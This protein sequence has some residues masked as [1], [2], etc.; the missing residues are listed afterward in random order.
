MRLLKKYRTYTYTSLVLVVL[1]GFVSN[2]HL[3]RRVNFR[4]ADEVLYSYQE[5][6][7]DFG[8]KHGTLE[9]LIAVNSKFGK[10]TRVGDDFDLGDTDGVIKDT[11]AYDYYQEEQIIYRKMLFSLSTGDG[12]YL[13][14]L[15]LPTLEEDY[16]VTTILFSL[17]IFTLLFILFTSMMDY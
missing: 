3:F 1:I 4:T 11:L 6:I 10:I 13:I 14:R 7:K 2:Y 16:L 8:E 17:L 12:K 9:P 15:M 5:D